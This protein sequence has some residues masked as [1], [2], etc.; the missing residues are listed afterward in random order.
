VRVER[1]QPAAA[2]STAD[3]RQRP[4]TPR[5]PPTPPL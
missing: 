2:M 4:P 1:W 5:Q 3:G